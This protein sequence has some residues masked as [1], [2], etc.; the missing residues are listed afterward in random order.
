[1]D[2][3]GRRSWRIGGPGIDMGKPDQHRHEG[4]HQQRRHCGGRA[5]TSAPPGPIRRRSGDGSAAR[6]CCRPE[7]CYRSQMP[8]ASR[9]AAARSVPPGIRAEP[10][11][12]DREQHGDADHKQPVARSVRACKLCRPGAHGSL[13]LSSGM[14]ASFAFWDSAAHEYRPRS[15][16]DRAARP[17]RRR[18]TSR[19]TRW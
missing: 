17:A 7:R 8:P 15:P 2:D 10:A 16:S 1:M 9:A 13:L 14:S 11:A 6:S 12:F 19:R 18:S 3:V 5:R 4:K